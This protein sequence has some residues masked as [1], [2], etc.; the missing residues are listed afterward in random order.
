MS[1]SQERIGSVSSR[2]G[3]YLMATLLLAGLAIG[4]V[5]ANA[6]APA[7]N[8]HALQPNLPRGVVAVGTA[9]R[10][11]PSTNGLLHSDMA[12]Y[13][14]NG[15]TYTS[16]AAEGSLYQ[17][18]TSGQTYSGN[19]RDNLGSAKIYPASGTN[20]DS[21]TLNG[22]YVVNTGN[23]RFTFHIGGTFTSTV[24]AKYGPHAHI[25]TILYG[26][27]VYNNRTPLNVSLGSFT[28]GAYMPP[29]TGTL[30]LTTDAIG[31]I[32][33]FFSNARASSTSS[34]AY[35]YKG[36]LYQYKISSYGRYYPPDGAGD[37]SLTTVL[38]IDTFTYD[39]IDA[40]EDTSGQKIISGDALAGS[41]ASTTQASFSAH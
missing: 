35:S 37:G 2:S 29:V 27:H 26:A 32:V 18:L 20:V 15:S 10:V 41:G 31:Y 5:A 25:G 12:I 30:T 36:N 9:G 14:S 3:R 8:K 40:Q 21:A 23:G 4:P 16:L 28:I 11:A 24:P 19:F 34:F 33:P 7:G 38:Q 1:R 13:V 17:R 6:A 22:D 39:I